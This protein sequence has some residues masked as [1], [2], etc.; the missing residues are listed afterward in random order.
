[1]GRVRRVI[2][3]RVRAGSSGS[4]VS[5]GESRTSGVRM[6]DNK[7]IKQFNPSMLE[8][9]DICAP[10]QEKEAVAAVFDLTGFTAFCNQVDSYLAIPR[11]LNDF[12]EWFFS[13]IRQKI[14][15]KDSR[16]PQRALDGTSHHGQV[17]G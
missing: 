6:I 17:S 12:L 13:N 2:V 1:M 5:P 10:C 11:F 15:E 4:R 9:G 16:G 8:L 7:T 14:T 3:R